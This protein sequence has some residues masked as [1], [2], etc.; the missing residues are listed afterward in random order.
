MIQFS[1]LRKRLINYTTQSG[2]QTFGETRGET[3]SACGNSLEECSNSRR[4]RARATQRKSHRIQYRH[5]E[6]ESPKRRSR[7]LVARYC[8][9]AQMPPG[10]L[11]AWYGGTGRDRGIESRPD[12]RVFERA[13]ARLGTRNCFDI[14]RG[15]T[16]TM[17]QFVI[18]RGGR[19]RRCV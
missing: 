2:K 4:A 5:R 8:L 16:A 10:T 6:E 18:P 1:R 14:A 7:A 9:L 12:H 15:T 11:V 19:A 3:N 13:S 17:R